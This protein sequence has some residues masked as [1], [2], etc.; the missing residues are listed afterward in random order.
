MGLTV[1]IWGRVQ[2]REAVQLTPSD[3]MM[4]SGSTGARALH[5]AAQ[6]TGTVDQ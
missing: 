1:D 5:R 6:S 3:P 2:E 4:Y